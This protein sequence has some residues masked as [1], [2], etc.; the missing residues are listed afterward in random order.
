M[1]EEI[2][3]AEMLEIPLSTVNVAKKRRKIKREKPALKESVI[4]HVN[5]KL[6]E[7][8]EQ[9][10]SEGTLFAE[11]ANGD[12][13]LV[14]DSVSER[15]DTVR[16][17][18]EDEKRQ[19]WE[20]ERLSAVDFKLNDHYED[21]VG[22]YEAKYG[23][24]AKIVQ[25]VLAGEF[26][27]CCVLCGAIF[28]T[29]VFVPSSAINTFFRALNNPAQETSDQR[30]YS[31]FEL[32]SVV[33]ELSDAKL[34]L[35]PTGILSFTDEGCVYPVADGTVQEVVKDKDGIY[36]LKIAHSD[37]FTEVVE[38]LDYVYY[39]V[40]ETV[41]ANVPIGYSEGET[42]VQV[43]MYSSGELLNCFQLS[44]DNELHWIVSES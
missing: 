41:K 12:G 21:E 8:P 5:G 32:S 38:G 29:N 6:Q 18:S 16:L 27:A 39:G 14:I 40:G 1:N 13:E 26:A 7:E 33:G 34:S 30:V 3:Y 44:E 35:S 17:Y 22:R 25:R 11:N 2:E 4:A 28:L 19:I 23:K 36:T 15:I 43:T 9:I 42:E 24:R 10:T 37:T 31:E 20:K